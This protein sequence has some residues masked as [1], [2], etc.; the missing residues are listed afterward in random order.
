MTTA[1]KKQ[2]FDVFDMLDE[3]NQTLIIEL[4]EA[5]APDD[6]ATPDDIQAHIEAVNDFNNGETISIDDI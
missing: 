1:V 6:I 5:L 4:I 2:A 3:K